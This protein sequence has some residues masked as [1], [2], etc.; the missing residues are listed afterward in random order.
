MLLM[1]LTA[2]TSM[3]QTTSKTQ[4][5]PTDITPPKAAKIPKEMRIHDDVRIDNYYWLNEKDNPNTIAYLEAEN[6]YVDTM[7]R[8]ARDF[9]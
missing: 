4:I 7:M 9:R 5:W 3:K 2:C 6:L 8:E 1:A